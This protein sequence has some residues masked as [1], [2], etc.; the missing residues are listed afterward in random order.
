MDR[1]IRYRKPFL[2]TLLIVLLQI[3]SSCY[4][5]LAFELQ[6]SFSFTK[7]S[8]TTQHLDHRNYAN[9]QVTSGWSSSRSTSYTISPEVI[10]T[11]NSINTYFKLAP[12][13]SWIF[14]GKTKDYPFKWDVEG[15]SKGIEIEAGYIWKVGGLFNFIPCIGFLY[16]I[17]DTSIHHQRFSHQNIGSY[18]RQ[19]GNKS[20]TTLY[21][22]YIGFE[23][24]FKTKLFCKHEVQLAFTYNF[25]YGGG[26][27]SNSVRKTVITI[28]PSTSRFGSNVKYHDLINHDFEFAIAYSLSKKW[29]LALEFDFNVTYNTKKLPLKY[30]HNRELVAKKQFTRSQYHV[31]SDFE[32]HTFGILFIIV[33]NFSGKGGGGEGAFISH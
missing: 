9:T 12:S 16:D 24:D 17:Y 23:L 26:H 31:I 4:A 22:P 33:Y 15:N 19:N 8:S 7:I 20:H 27:G 6:N 30:H 11:V 3:G 29:T 14:D 1:L 13:Y 21:F 10:W 32:S 28:L 18:I 25:G 5:D 2:V